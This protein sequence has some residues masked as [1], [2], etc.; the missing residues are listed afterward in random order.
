MQDLPWFAVR[1]R[2]Q[3]VAF[4]RDI[5]GPREGGYALQVLAV[6]KRTR[7]IYLVATRRAAP[8]QNIES[9]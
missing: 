8:V 1:N 3:K 9:S 7:F 4:R 5:E 6:V 2:R